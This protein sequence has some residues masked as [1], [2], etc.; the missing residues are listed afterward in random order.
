M[1]EDE[2]NG[3]TL[4]LQFDYV[5]ATVEILVALINFESCKETSESRRA[6]IMCNHDR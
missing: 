4:L 6:A 2:K 1:F 3:L 5:L